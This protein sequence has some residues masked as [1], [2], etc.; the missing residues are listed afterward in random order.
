MAISKLQWVFSHWKWWFSIVMLKYQRVVILHPLI[1]SSPIYP[2]CSILYLE[3]RCPRQSLSFDQTAPSQQQSWRD[4][5]LDLQMVFGRGWNGSYRCWAPTFARPWQR[6]VWYVI[7]SL[8]LI[9]NNSISILFYTCGILCG[10]STGL[11]MTQR[12][13]ATPSQ[14]AGVERPLAVASK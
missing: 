2:P 14:P 5:L 1:A 12:S 9:S 11:S 10:C 8:N 13:S 3:Q 4:W 7:P 6:S